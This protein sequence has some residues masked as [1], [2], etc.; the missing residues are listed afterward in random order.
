LLGRLVQVSEGLPHIEKLIASQSYG[1]ATL[2][3]ASTRDVLFEIKQ[4][5]GD[6][7]L[8]LPSL[9]AELNTQE[10]KLLSCIAGRWTEMVNWK[11]SPVVLTISSGPEALLELEQLSQSLQNIGY[12]SGIVAKFAS[13]VMT[14]IVNKLLS[15][16]VCEVQIKQDASSVSIKIVVS[17]TGET[18]R[19]VVHKLQS[20][21]ML[22]ETLYQHLLRVN[23]RNEMS[24]SVKTARECNGIKDVVLAASR[25]KDLVDVKSS[26]SLMSM[27]GD[28]CS[29][30]CIE[31]LISH[32]LALAIP[33]C[34]SELAQF[35][36]IQQ[37]V[38][39]MNKK[40]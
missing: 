31:R 3:R 40:E 23:V 7:V 32:C 19:G 12:L 10:E 30:A 17:A 1:E 28:A 14:L 26:R 18:E 15:E 16:D 27:F 22:I 9:V 25:E 6:E 29:D 35:S 34:R 33:S 5:Y 38:E 36:P 13:K 2:V 20:F 11:S 24:S 37:A 21:T 39:G 8:V 4:V